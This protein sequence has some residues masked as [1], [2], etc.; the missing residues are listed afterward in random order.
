[1]N[2]KKWKKEDI[3]Q[4]LIEN[5]VAVLRGLLRIYDLQTADEKQ[6][7]DTKYH[8]NI[9]FNGVDGYIMSKFA[10]FYMSRGY[11]TSKQ[12]NLTKK[13]IMKYSGQLAKIANGIIPEARM[14]KITII[15][16]WL[17]Q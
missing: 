9:G 5:D 17:R 2:S 12:F 10:S 6:D 4:L 14:T 8:N 1:M 11:L 7:D 13:K 3:K 16:N 15:K